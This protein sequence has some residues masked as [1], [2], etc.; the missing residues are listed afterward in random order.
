MCNGENKNKILHGSDFYRIALSCD[1]DGC[2]YDYCV[3]VLYFIIIVAHVNVLLDDA[4]YRYSTSEKR[5]H[6]PKGLLSGRD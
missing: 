4:E 3:T 5:H 2:P 6:H 1:G